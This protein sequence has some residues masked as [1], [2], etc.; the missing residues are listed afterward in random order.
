MDGETAALRLGE[1][2]KKR[3]RPAKETKNPI[4]GKDAVKGIPPD[5][6][7]GRNLWEE[8]MTL[9]EKRRKRRSRKKSLPIIYKL[10]EKIQYSAQ[11]FFEGGKML[12]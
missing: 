5:E 8:A 1:K 6:V 11:I 10:N 7:C 12:G 4:A 2:I 3:R 9:Y